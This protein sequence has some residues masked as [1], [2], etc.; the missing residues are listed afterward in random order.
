MIP[1]HA[2]K[3]G[4][5]NLGQ[6]IGLTTTMSPREWIY[7]GEADLPKWLLRPKAGRPEFFRD[8][9]NFEAQGHP[10]QND[11]IRFFRRWQNAAI[12]Y[13][14]KLPKH[15]L[16][17]LAYAQ[18]YGLA[19]RLL[20]WS[21]N[22]LVALFFAV[23]SDEDADAVVYCYFIGGSPPLEATVDITKLAGVRF[24]IP[25][26]FDR[27]ILAQQGVFTIHERPHEEFPVVSEA[28]QN[29]ELMAGT[30]EKAGVGSFSRLVAVTIPARFKRILRR[31]LRDI[32]ITRN[33]LFPDLEG[34]SSFINREA[35]E[36]ARDLNALRG[37]QGLTV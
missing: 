37:Q 1:K 12:A 33:T 25:R 6:F 31:Q 13:R 20:D 27:R 23:D 10:K 4:F 18:H 36:E 15:D 22:P 35:N 8:L 9:T 5:E 2:R 14:R 7:R 17:C 29:Y 32:G 26:P 30:L 19:T 16:E 11:D 24:Y 28:A 21:R 3:V 34:L